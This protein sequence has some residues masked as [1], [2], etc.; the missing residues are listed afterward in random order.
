[1]KRLTVDG[2]AIG[3]IDATAL[4]MLVDLKAELAGQ[5]IELTM[6]DLRPSVLQMLQRSG[7]DLLSR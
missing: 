1:L 7:E 5:A 2:T 6:I 3:S 4:G